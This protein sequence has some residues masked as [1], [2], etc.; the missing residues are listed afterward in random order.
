V[1]FG[2]QVA[3]ESPEG[4]P[5]RFTGR[6][7]NVSKS[8]LA[9]F[10]QGCFTRGKLVRVR[11]ALPRDGSSPGEKRV[12]LLGIMKWQRVLP[13]GNL[14]GIELLADDNVADYRWF[15]NWIQVRSQKHPIRCD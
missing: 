7:I 6:L 14:L 8:G 5:A 15:L 9:M 2:T 4:T 3:V 12:N 11:F 10:T 13:E 1:F